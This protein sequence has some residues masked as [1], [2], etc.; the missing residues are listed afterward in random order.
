LIQLGLDED[1]RDNFVAALENDYDEEDKVFRTD[2]PLKLLSYIKRAK[3]GSLPFNQKYKKSLDKLK[4]KD[5][6]ETLGDLLVRGPSS[7]GMSFLG[8]GVRGFK[9][10]LGGGCLAVVRIPKTIL[11]T[12]GGEDVLL[13]TF[14][15]RKLKQTKL[16]GVS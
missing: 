1:E 9:E 7:E 11:V 13:L 10:L 6:K 8:C 4:E 3:G 12:G 5:R 15:E 16:R 14:E 2:L